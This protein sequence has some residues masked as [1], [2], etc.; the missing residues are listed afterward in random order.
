MSDFTLEE[1]Y[2]DIRQGAHAGSEARQDYLETEF[3]LSLTNELEGA[4]V[5]EGV[6]LCHYRRPSGGM[7][8]D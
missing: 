4:G 7:R 8:F 1:F 3:L 6:E 2:K 5:V